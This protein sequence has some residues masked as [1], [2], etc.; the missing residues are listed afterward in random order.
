MALEV[1][2]L[3]IVNNLVM[4]NQGTAAPEANGRT[5]GWEATCEFTKGTGRFE[6][7]QG[8]RLFT[9]KRLAAT[10]GAGAQYYTDYGLAYALPSR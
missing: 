9:G 1:S 5:T 7:L 4:A 10:P 3:G 6:G 2:S 8:G